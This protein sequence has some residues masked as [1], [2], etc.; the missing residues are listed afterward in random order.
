MVATFLLPDVN[1]HTE[2]EPFTMV[3]LQP[4]SERIDKPLFV[5]GWTM[6]GIA[7][8]FPNLVTKKFGNPC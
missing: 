5:L 4:A 6:V 2:H 3:L 8:T 7:Q 1:K